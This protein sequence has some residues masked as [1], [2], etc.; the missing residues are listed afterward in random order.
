ME[1][2]ICYF[3][4]HSKANCKLVCITGKSIRKLKR[5]DTYFSSDGQQIIVSGRYD[6]SISVDESIGVVDTVR[7]HHIKSLASGQLGHSSIQLIRKRF[8]AIE[9]NRVLLDVSVAQTVLEIPSKEKKFK[10]RYSKISFDHSANRVAYFSKNT[11]VVYFEQLPTTTVLSAPTITIRGANNKGLNLQGV[12]VSSSDKLSDKNIV[13]LQKRGDYGAFQGNLLNKLFPNNPEGFNDVREISV[14]DEKLAPIHARIIAS[15]TYWSNLRKLDLSRNAIEEEGGEAIGDNQS[16]PHLEELNL[17]ETQIGDKTAIKV[18]NNHSWKNLKKLELASNK[19]GN[20]GAIEIGKCKIWVNLEILNLY[21]NEIEDEGARTISTNN[22]WEK[23]T[24]LDLR[25]N[26]INEKQT[27]ISL[28]INGTWKALKCLYLGYILAVLEATDALKAIEDITSKSLEE[29]D[30]P[31]ARFER[32]LL[33]CLKYNESKSVLVL[34]LSDNRYNALHAGI[35][36]LNTTW[37]NLQTLNLGSNSIGDKGATAL[38]HNTTW[39]NLRTLNLRFNSIGDEGTTALSQNI[40]WINLKTLDMKGNWIGNEGASS[41][42][43][44]AWPKNIQ[45]NTSSSYYNQVAYSFSFNF[46]RVLKMHFTF[47]NL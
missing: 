28:C 21:R 35:I 39:T 14:I 20:I 25:S 36:G 31:G 1:F 32:A 6:E 13:I 42:K 37:I 29:I 17:A 19:I 18:A 4:G 41:L 3:V 38:S 16:W 11:G 33:Q 8:L 45:I 15:N 23:L 9:D 22:T 12:I 5:C 44:Q 7:G 10:G 27:V 46:S 24:R 30:L 34:P 47:Q 40:S 43:N 2:Q 26:K